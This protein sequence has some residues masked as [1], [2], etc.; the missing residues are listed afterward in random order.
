MVWCLVKH[1]DFSVDIKLRVVP[2]TKHHAVVDRW[3]GGEVPRIHNLGTKR[4]WVVRVTLRPLYA[5]CSFAH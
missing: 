2:G 3:R 1:R 4:I 5:T